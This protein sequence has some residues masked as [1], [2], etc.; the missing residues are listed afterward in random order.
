M[1]T[2]KDKKNEY[3]FLKRLGIILLTILTIAFCIIG[4]VEYII[5]PLE[6]VCFGNEHPFALCVAEYIIDLMEKI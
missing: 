3:N 4:S 5:Y 6:W 1:K 2:S